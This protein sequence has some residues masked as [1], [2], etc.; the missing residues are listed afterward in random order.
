MSASA[1]CSVTD[2]CEIV[3]LSI[4]MCEVKDPLILSFSVN[5]QNLSWGQF[6]CTYGKLKNH[7]SFD[8][9]SSYLRMHPKKKILKHEKDVQMVFNGKTLG[10]WWPYTADK[11]EINAAS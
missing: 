8:P 6:G 2:N 3:I 7:L 5:W 4:T 10:K 9:F 11:I 1:T